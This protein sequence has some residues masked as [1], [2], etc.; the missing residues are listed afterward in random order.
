M[1]CSNCGHVNAATARF[2]A[3]CGQSLLR[4]F[5]PDCGADCPVPASQCPNGHSLPLPA[6]RL[7]GKGMVLAGRY[8]IEKLLGCGGFGAVYLAGDLRFQ[9]RQVA[10]K[11][12]HDPTVLNSFLKEAELLANLH[13]P[14]LP[15]VSDFFQE[16]VPTIPQPRP[17]MVMDYIEGEELWERIQKQGKLSEQEVLD[18]LKGVFDALEYLHGLQPPIFH[19]D[20]KPQNIRITPDGR[21]FLVD[22]GIAKV[23]GAMTTTGSRA[24]TP[25][26]APPEQY[27]MAGETDERSDQYALAMTIYV[28]L[29]G[30]VPIHAEATRR[31]Q[32]ITTRAPDPLEPLSKVAPNIS[33]RVEKAVMKALSVEKRNRFSSIKEFRQALYPPMI[34]GMTRRQF[35]T[36][37]L[38]TAFSL[39][40]LAF[41][42]YQF[43]KWRQPLWLVAELKGHNA[44]VTWVAFTPDGNKVLSA[45]HDKTIRVWD[46][47]KSKCER[48]LKGHKDSIRCLA[49][50]GNE[51]VAS[52]SWDGTVRIWNWR[53]GKQQANLVAKVGQLN[54]LAVNQNGQWLVAGGERGVFVRRKNG[55]VDQI[56]LAKNVRSM[57]FRPNSQVLAIGDNAGQIWLLNLAQH[58][59]MAKWR[60]HQSAVTALAFHP[61][62][63]F[64]FS[65]SEDTTLA[66]WDI[67]SQSLVKRLGGWHQREIRAVAFSPDGKF[68]VSCSM[69]DR[70]RVW[71]VKDWQLLLTKE[72]GRNWALALAFDP[73]GNF[74]ASASKDEK[75]KVWR[76]K[77]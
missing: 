63:T 10:V 53:T 50:M 40:V 37:I 49:L 35:A 46:W 67:V 36:T 17:Y 44:G 38:A 77:F 15:R 12:N 23:G 6:Q 66:V 31:E 21:T 64:L 59:L 22:F 33:S 3:Q 30:Q 45:S 43:W 42:G 41:G 13:H 5:C 48:I 52:A 75:V 28:A 51:L 7:L 24:A 74:I 4:Q 68:A 26:F 25:P 29:T 47:R 69:D 56:L 57:A 2:C 34:V 32:A 18:L 19:R 73:S 27:R 58:K 62:G 54:A 16:H 76:V 14:N 39:S 72:G 8:R 11:E 71:Q 61:N 9:Q 20:I 65:G 55:K 60:A 1:V 70:L